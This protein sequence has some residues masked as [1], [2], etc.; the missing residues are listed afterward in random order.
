M[1]ENI[2]KEKSYAF[3]VR[4]VKL[5]KYLE[6]NKKE[7][8]LSN[9]LKRSGTAPGALVRESEHAESRKDFVHKLSIA[10]KEANESDYWLNLLKEGDYITE[11]EFNSIYAD[12]IEIIKLLTSILKSTKNN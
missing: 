10:L 3:G 11:K 2:I 1:K 4:I 7:F 5:C 12:C 6:V 8:I 9:Q